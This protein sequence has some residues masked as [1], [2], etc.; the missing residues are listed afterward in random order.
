MRLRFAVSM[1]TNARNSPV[2]SS[3]ATLPPLR[4]L[5]VDDDALVLQSLR[6]AL[7]ID[8]HLVVTASSGEA[9]LGEFRAALARRE[10]FAAVI[11]DLGM[12]HMDG[13]QVASTV[14]AMSPSTPVILLTGWGQQLASEGD[15]PPHVN[16]VLSK[17]PKL[18][19]LRDALAQYCPLSIPSPS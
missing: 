5:V 7:A 3:S 4:L 10:P 9:A 2:T 16:R 6:D 13:R 15:V 14:K 8:G 1:N 17:P 11:T 18:R 19:E 12:P